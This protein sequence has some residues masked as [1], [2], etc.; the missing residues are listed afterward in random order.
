MTS[1]I[2]KNIINDNNFKWEIKL[3]LRI[4][5]QFVSDTRLWKG[6]NIIGI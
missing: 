4:K 5:F 1:Q 3:K 2:M 6:F